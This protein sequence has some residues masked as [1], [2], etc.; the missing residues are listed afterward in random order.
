[1][2]TVG[3]ALWAVLVFGV[4]L[5]ALFASCDLFGMKEE[6]PVS[7]TVKYHANGGVGK[8]ENST[9]PYGKDVTLPP[10]AFTREG[11]A[12]SSWT[13]RNPN[14]DYS[15]NSNQSYND[16]YYKDGASIWNDSYSVKSTLNLY[17]LWSQTVIVNFDANG[18][19]GEMADAVLRDGGMG[20]GSVQ[21]LPKNAFTRANYTFMGWATSPDGPKVYQDQAAL[22]FDLNIKIYELEIGAAITLYAVWSSGSY[23]VTYNANGGYGRWGPVE[24]ET[25]EFDVE[26]ALSKNLFGHSNSILIGWSTSVNGSMVYTNGQT[27]KNLAS[28]GETVNLYA[29][30][31]RAYPVYFHNDSGGY[32][33]S[34]DSRSFAY[35]APQALPANTFTRPGYVFAGWATVSGGPVVYADQ[36]IFT[37]P[38][39]GPLDLY[40]VWAL[41]ADL[42]YVRYDA[43]GGS[44]TMG[45]TTLSIS[46]PQNLS[47][48]RFTRP[49]YAFQG[50][51]ESP[52]GAVKY[53]DQASVTNLASAGQTATLYAVWKVNTYTVRYD[54][55]NGSGT[56]MAD[57][58]FTYDQEQNLRKNTFTRTDYIF[59]GWA[60]SQTATSPTYIDEQSVKNLTTMSNGTVTLYAVWARTYTVAYNANG[61][62]GTD[63]ASQT[64]TYGEAQNLRA[65]T[66]TRPGYTFAGWSTSQTAA[67]PTYTDGQRVS[68]LTSMAG[69]TVDLYAVW[70][71][72]YTVMYN[73]NGGSGSMA[74][75]AFV[76]GTAQNL[77]ANAFTKAGYTFMGWAT[78]PEGAALGT[79]A[80]TNGQ[81]VNSLTTE[82]NK[83]V[84]LYA[85]WGAGDYTVAYNANGGTGTAMASQTFTFGVEKALS[86]NTYTRAGYNFGG[87]ARSASGAKVYNDEQSVSNLASAAGQ[88]VDLYAVWLNNY[89]VAY[90]SNGGSGT[91]MANQAF[92]YGT[93]QNL[94]TNGFTRLGYTFAGWAQTSTG[95]VEYTNGQSVNNLTT[96]ANGT[97]TLYAVWN[98]NTYTVNYLANGGTG[99][100][101]RSTFI[102][103]ESQALSM[104][105]FT[106]AN[107][108]FDGWSASSTEYTDGQIVSNLT[109]TANGTVNLYARWIDTYTIKYDGNGSTSTYHGT[110]TM[111]DQSFTYGSERKLQTNDYYRDGYKFMG[112]ARSPSGPVVYNNVA[113]VYITPQDGHPVTLY[114]VWRNIY[115]VAY[116]KNAA[117][118]AGTM[119]SQSFTYDTAQ[120]LRNNNFTRSGYAF[121]G[122]AESTNGPVKYA[123]G[124]NVVN[125]TSTPNGT[126]TLYAKWTVSNYSVKYDSNGGGGNMQDTAFTY[127]VAGSLRLNAFTRSGHLFIGWA[128]STNGPV[129]YTNGQSVINLT[130]TAGGI[131]TLYAVWSNTYTVKYNANYGSGTMSDSVFT[132]DIADNL[133]ANT[134]TRLG[135]TFAGWA[136]TSTGPVEYTDGQSVTNMATTETVVNLYAVWNAHN[137]TVVYNA[138]GDNVT[139]SM[140]DQS[141]TYGTAQALRSNTFNRTNYTFAGWATSSDA[142]TVQYTNGQNGGNMAM[143]AGA[144]VTLYAVWRN[145]YT[146]VFNA[147]VTTGVTGSMSPQS[148]VYGTA[149][150]L[151]K[152]N[153]ARS[154]SVFQG[155]ATSPDGPRAYTDEQSVTDLTT[156]AGA[157]F[158][159]YAVWAS[160]YTIKYNANGGTGTMADSLGQLGQ[161]VSL[162]A[163]V[164]TRNNYRFLGWSTNPNATTATYADGASVNMTSTSGGTLYAIWSNTYTVIYNGN[165]NTGGTAVADQTFTLGTS[166]ALRSNSF[167]RTNCTFAGWSASSTATTAT[168]TAG[169][170]VSNLTTTAA[171]YTLYAVWQNNY[172]VIFN[173]NSNTG[174]SMSNQTIY[175]SGQFNANNFTRTNYAFAGW[176]TTS[177]GSVAYA[178]RATAPTNLAPA[179]GS[180]TL[181][182][183]WVSPHTVVYNNNGG[184][185]TMTNS[186]FAVGT[187]QTLPLNT[188][189][190]TG[191]TFIGWATSAVALNGGTVAYGDRAS[192]TASGGQTTLYAVWR[193]TYTVS[194]ATSSTSDGTMAAQSFVYGTAQNLN[195]NTYN[196]AGSTFQG[197]ATS[198]YD[199]SLGTVTYSNRANVNNLTATPGGTVT[200]WAVWR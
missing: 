148:F 166:Q 174:G 98:P 73:A 93:A 200:L 54:A 45:N 113:T 197:W 84:T 140:S 80:Y 195:A 94:R 41:N 42:Y 56:A 53:A 44:G 191:C 134:F 119:S 155:W 144:T 57:T 167:T 188:F 150:N 125:L 182:A 105:T 153:F 164:F 31:G 128:E 65:N 3:K 176:A 132:F 111:S 50:W 101:E 86:K 178:D 160:Y 69:G 76:W 70:H 28:A 27:V 30:W 46:A 19:A 199:A 60:T 123:D 146:V 43:N 95:A 66:F 179:G 26:R 189:T 77:R 121:A 162:Q 5:A 15:Y 184:T 81:S 169:Q 38:E 100:M 52:N 2:K 114:A 7:Y 196:R 99:A 59:R 79:V 33:G 85:V 108:R 89:T 130:S 171:T 112:W 90:N 34:M 139:G 133:R 88:T 116:D 13:T 110:T 109:T 118:A 122:W 21:R 25:F 83:I 4:L 175:G 156:E 163:N 12:F 190:R 181:Y 131:V 138:N 55:N 154:G 39:E 143:A 147:N 49:G 158:N 129:K 35:G 106:R 198:Q 193:T 145:N 124:Q 71:N 29:V 61:G 186:S 152:N 161:S 141:F 115:Q 194:F 96:A 117:D 6:E 58:S 63:M 37:L 1:L 24:S 192:F 127:D 16:K 51:A 177:G 126:V 183:V 48:C 68:N 91:A 107:Y 32:G 168:Y 137:Y 172:T 97:V 18:G 180:I 74:D 64:F 36:E 75:T 149:Q 78:S 92:V 173:G 135:Y 8:M 102:Y 47:Y 151:L 185:G 67:S 17:A 72:N 187:S 40:A 11:Y 20:D 103:G 22:G 120:N 82:A 23:T 9:F 14:V 136:R 157:T 10:N 62:T 165:G 87:W 104:N 159:L 142:A 170:T